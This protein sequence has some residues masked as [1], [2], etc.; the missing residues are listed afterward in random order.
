MK[1]GDF[2]I[3]FVGL[4]VNDWF[5][6]SLKGLNALKEADEIFA[7]FYTSCTEFG[8]ND[9]E[10][11]IGKKI[12]L[13]KRKDVE[14]NSGLILKAA[15]KKNVVF[16]VGGDAMSATTHVDLRLRA[17]RKG[18]KTRLIHASSIYTAAI[19][20]CGLQLYKFGKSATVVFQEKNFTPSSFYD[21]V[22]ENKKL[23]LHTFLFLDLRAEENR[24]MTA[25]DAISI[26]RKIESEK[27]KGIFSDDSLAVVCARVGSTDELVRFGKVSE[28]AE[29]DFGKPLHVLIV[30]GNLHDVELESLELLGKKK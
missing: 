8:I 15:E 21:V 22:C 29:E 30:P 7:E 11:E 12:N 18:I 17:I 20:S 1:K 9:L 5:D 28:L 6:V 3:S 13:L 23:G 24:Y 26:L 19:G 16:L 25:N 4:G 10:K 14:T 27:N 2:L